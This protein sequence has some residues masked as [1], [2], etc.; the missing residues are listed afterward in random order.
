MGPIGPPLPC[1]MW[2]RGPRCLSSS[3]RRLCL[4]LLHLGELRPGTGFD[5]GTCTPANPCAAVSYALTQAASGATIEL[6]KAPEVL[7][8]G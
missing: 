7:Q 4:L 3:R 2:P 6:G 8:D 5:S 1:S